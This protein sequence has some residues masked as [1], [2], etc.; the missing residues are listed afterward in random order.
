MEVGEAVRSVAKIGHDGD[1]LMKRLRVGARTKECKFKQKELSF[2][3]QGLRPLE[4]L[5][6]KSFYI[7]LYKIRNRGK[8]FLAYAVKCEY[9][10]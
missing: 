4:N 10:H 2:S 7:Q 3:K 6:L 9:R 8:H 5:L 1:H